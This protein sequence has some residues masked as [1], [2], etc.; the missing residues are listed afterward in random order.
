MTLHQSA[1]HGCKAVAVA[2]L[3]RGYFMQMCKSVPTPQLLPTPLM[4]LGEDVIR[5]YTI[6]CLL[7]HHHLHHYSPSVNSEGPLKDSPL[8][9]MQR[10]QGKEMGVMECWDTRAGRLPAKATG[11]VTSEGQSPASQTLLFPPHPPPSTPQG[12]A[13]CLSSASLLGGSHLP[14]RL[15]VGGCR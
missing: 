14:S 10:Q 9:G 15:K 6:F 7:L 2:K 5:I 12:G 1:L 4:F 3:V 8:L 11:P 13:P